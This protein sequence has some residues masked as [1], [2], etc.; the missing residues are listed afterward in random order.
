MMVAANT[1]V[2][3]FVP[4][5]LDVSDFSKLEPLYRALLDRQIG[6]AAELERWMAD[7]SELTAVVKKLASQKYT[8][9]SCHTDDKKIEAAYMNFVEN[10][11]PKIK[12]I[13]FE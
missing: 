5:Q 11:E 2:R 1:P 6:S 7:L 8:D 3:K 12:P 10:V 13:F 9:K 4:Q